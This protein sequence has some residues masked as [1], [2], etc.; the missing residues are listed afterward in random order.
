MIPLTTQTINVTVLDDTTVAKTISLDNK[1]RLKFG[2]SLWQK[3]IHF[4]DKRKLDNKI[5]REVKELFRIRYHFEDEKTFARIW[6][7]IGAHA[8][9]PKSELTVGKLQEIDNQFKQNLIYHGA[10]I[11]APQQSSNADQRIQHIVKVLLHG[12]TMQKTAVLDKQTFQAVFMKHDPY[13]MKQFEI[14]LQNELNNLAAAPPKTPEEEIVWRAFLGNVLTLMPFCYPASGE[15]FSIPILE[16]GVC[17]KVDYNLEVLSLPYS[18]KS[19][20]MTALGLTP[21]NDPKAPPLISFLGTT[22]P[23]AS[24]FAATIL[25]DFTPGKSVGETVYDRNEKTIDNWMRDKKD[26]HALGVSLGGAMSFHLLRHYQDKVSHV[27]VFVPPGLYP[28]AWKNEINEECKVNIYTQPGDIVSELGVWPTGKNVNVYRIYQHQDLDENLLSSHARAFAGCN[29]ITIVKEDPAKVN[30]S[31]K[32][33]FI[34]RLHRFLGPILVYL[35]VSFSVYFYHLMSRIQS[36]VANIFHKDN[37]E[38]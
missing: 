25:A 20:P 29:N 31:S 4:N 28:E 30:T 36:F 3:I 21:K 7:K 33:K 1:D 8:W 18:D 5:T 38:S 35:P 11:A 16:N 15:V 14:E 19:T 17:R 6:N 37:T 27:D 2:S 26:V 34:T 9:S 24:G 22:F 12:A 10:G 13:L 32:R 23:A